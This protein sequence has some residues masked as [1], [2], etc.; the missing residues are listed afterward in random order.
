V[1][2]FTAIISGILFAMVAVAVVGRFLFRWLVVDLWRR[3]SSIYGV[4]D[5]R[6]IIVSS[7]GLQRKARSVPLESLTEISLRPGR[8]QLGTIT[9]GRDV[10]LAFYGWDRARAIKEG[11]APAFENIEDAAA[12]LRIISKAQRLLLGRSPPLPSPA[13]SA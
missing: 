1:L 4:T 2:V 10:V 7:G 11:L 6:L 8:S 3:L 9:F 13:S 12:I 5:A